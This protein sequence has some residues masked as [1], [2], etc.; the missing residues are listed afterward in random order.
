MKYFVTIALPLDDSEV[1]KMSPCGDSSIPVMLRIPVLE[2]PIGAVETWREWRRF[3]ANTLYASSASMIS[4]FFGHNYIS[5]KQ[6]LMNHMLEPPLTGEW[7]LA[8]TAKKH[9]T[10][11]E[12]V[13]KR[14]FLEI[15]KPNNPKVLETGDHTKLTL[16][17]DTAQKRSAFLMTTPD[18]IVEM[19]GSKTIA[20]FKCPYFELFTPSLRNNR[21]VTLVA[22]DFMHKNPVGKENSF[23][24]SLTYALSEDI[25]RFFV[26]YY[27]TDTIDE[28]VVIYEYTRANCTLLT[29]DI[30]RAMLNIKDQLGKEP[31]DIKVRTTTADKRNVTQSMKLYFL[32]AKIYEFKTDGKWHSLYSDSSDEESSDDSEDDGPHIPGEPGS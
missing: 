1:F 15:M 16:F 32:N 28:A 20:E 19:N 10:D 25:D 31:G 17:F 26:C 23:L 18:M 27:F 2:Y 4:G 12:P 14:A 5:Y 13:A 9:G 7:Q 29:R 6:T 11:H 24:Q 22:M 3:V 30:M 21:S 8:D